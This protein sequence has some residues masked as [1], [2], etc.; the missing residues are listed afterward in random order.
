VNRVVKNMQDETKGGFE[1]GLRDLATAMEIDPNDSLAY[2]YRG[3]FYLMSSGTG[4]PDLDLAIADFT[5]AI[6]LD[7]K[8]WRAYHWRGMMHLGKHDYEL[9]VKDLNDAIGLNPNF[10][11]T[12]F[13]RS[14]A[15]EK[16]GQKENA[17]AD[18][19]KWEQLKGSLIP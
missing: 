9:A 5:T 2:L 1:E 12:Y 7:F 18:K 17:A 10:G 13:Y 16:L 15:Y 8:S 4:E 19:Q 3:Q 11:G 6:R 14:Q